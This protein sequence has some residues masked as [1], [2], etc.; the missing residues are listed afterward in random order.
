M[1]SAV[2]AGIGQEAVAELLG[3]AVEDDGKQRGEDKKQRHPPEKDLRARELGL[4][5]DWLPCGCRR[6]SSRS[7]R[8]R[9]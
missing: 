8:L 3:L 5:G 2:Q 4:V 7:R 9:D 1:M 6:S